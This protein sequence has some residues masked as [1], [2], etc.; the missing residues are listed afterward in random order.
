ME[1]KEY[2]GLN[3]LKDM[4]D[5]DGH[6]VMLATNTWP[7]HGKAAD[8]GKTA[9]DVAKDLGWDETIWDLSGEEPVLKTIK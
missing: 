7:W 3:P 5:L 4:A 1:F 6:A 8:A 9:S 2:T